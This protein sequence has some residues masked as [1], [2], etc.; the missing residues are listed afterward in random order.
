LQTKE[1]EVLLDG[2]AIGVRGVKKKKEENKIIDILFFCYTIF[3]RW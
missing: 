3:Y 2:V 1:K